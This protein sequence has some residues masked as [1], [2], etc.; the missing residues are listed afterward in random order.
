MTLTK[1]TSVF[2]G[3][4][5]LCGLLSTLYTLDLVWSRMTIRLIFS[6]SGS[7]ARRRKSLRR[8][9]YF[10]LMVP[11]AVLAILIITLLRFI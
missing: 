9:D 3:D 1:M 7:E 5:S 10:G 8:D 6:L 11:V 4:T 2:N